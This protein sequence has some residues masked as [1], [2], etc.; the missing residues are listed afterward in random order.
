MLASYGVFVD[1]FY[2]TEEV[3]LYSYLSVSD[4]NMVKLVTFFPC[5][6]WDDP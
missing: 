5:V 3:S 1:A 4:E 2:Q 6:Y